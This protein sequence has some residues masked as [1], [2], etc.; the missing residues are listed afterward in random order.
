[1]QI[2]PVET[3]IENVEEELVDVEHSLG[4]TEFNICKE[5]GATV[6]RLTNNC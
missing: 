1:M 3:V 6:E 2:D 5:T 4:N